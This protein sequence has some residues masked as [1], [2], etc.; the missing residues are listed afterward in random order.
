MLLTEVVEAS[1]RVAASSARTAKI[2]AL[3]DLLRRLAPDE[4]EPAVGFLVGEPR[5]GRIGV[6]WATLAKAVAARRR[7][8]DPEPT[9]ERITIVDLDRAL[10]ELEVTIGS[11]SVAARAALI[12]ALLVRASSAEMI[13]QPATTGQGTTITRLQITGCSAHGWEQI[14][15]RIRIIPNTAI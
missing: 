1:A 15:M 9:G 10:D 11:G 5:Q 2:A 14:A 6:G 12:D 4:V 8:V 3:A 7:E 13:W